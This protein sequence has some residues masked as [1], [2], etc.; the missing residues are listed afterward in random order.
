MGGRFYRMVGI[1]ALG[2]YPQLGK[3]LLFIIWALIWSKAELC[4]CVCACVCVLGG[5]GRWAG[6]NMA[7]FT[8]LKSNTRGVSYNHVGCELLKLSP[9]SVV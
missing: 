1:E 4:V 8:F 3:H 5:C 9:V 2:A 7:C 6:T